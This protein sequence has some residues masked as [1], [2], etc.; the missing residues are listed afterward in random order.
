MAVY[1]INK[2]ALLASLQQNQNIQTYKIEGEELQA[3]EVSV[4]VGSV[5]I[6]QPDDEGFLGHPVW[7]S[8]VL[9]AQGDGENEGLVLKSVI[10]EISQQRNIVSTAMAGKDGTV[11]EYVSK[12]DY[13]VKIT[14][15]V[16]ANTTNETPYDQ[17]KEMANYL[18]KPEA[19]KAE[20]SKLLKA[21]G[22]TNLVCENYNFGNIQGM[23]N[24]R[25]FEANFIS[26]DPIEL[27]LLD[28]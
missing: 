24:V 19:L 15:L 27:T 11:K 14:G 26:D 1:V 6:A 28:E 13:L 12:G 16:T 9:K 3:G 20:S 7:Q 8:L 22:I 21:F 18:E 25:P 23:L 2:Q 5:E 10:M 4:D 17:M